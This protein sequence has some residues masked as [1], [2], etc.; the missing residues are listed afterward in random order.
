M[1]IMDV[2]DNF[3]IS[4]SLDNLWNGG[5]D[6][7]LHADDICEAKLLIFK[8]PINYCDLNYQRLALTIIFMFSLQNKTFYC[9]FCTVW[10]LFVWFLFAWFF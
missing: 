4:L 10:V 6:T 3:L 9:H 1:T 2:M 7:S 8:V 5:N